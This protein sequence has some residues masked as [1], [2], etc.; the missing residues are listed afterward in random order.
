MR[1]V[2]VRSSVHLFDDDRRLRSG[3]AQGLLMATRIDQ[4]TKDQITRLKSQ[5]ISSQSCGMFSLFSSEPPGHEAQ[6][7]PR[8]LG[9]LLM[10][11]GETGN[12]ISYA[13]APASVVAP[14]GTV[15][16]FSVPL[17]TRS[18]ASVVCSD[19]E[20]PLCSFAA[21]RAAPQ[22]KKLHSLS[23]TSI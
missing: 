15:N 2:F 21:P 18:H 14:L 4:P 3:R 22:S 17:R 16:K 9:F 5:S 11:V 23:L 10:N 20:L 19:S 12:F 1:T 6:I 8:W 13:F 7:S